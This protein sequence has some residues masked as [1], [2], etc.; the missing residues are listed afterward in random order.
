MILTCKNH[1]TVYIYLTLKL[2][3]RGTPWGDFQNSQSDKSPYG[4]LLFWHILQQNRG[5]P[6]GYFYYNLRSEEHL[7]V[8][9]Y[10]T[11]KYDKV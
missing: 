1:L 3:K 9:L 10:F 4:V 11:A 6:Q 7:T 5:T 2:V 8:R